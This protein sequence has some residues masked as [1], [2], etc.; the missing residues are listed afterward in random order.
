MPKP[1]IVLPYD[2]DVEQ[3]PPSNSSNVVKNNVNMAQST[4]S[5]YH[6]YLSR[7]TRLL[8]IALRLA[9][10]NIIDE[11]LN[12]RQ[13]DGSYNGNS[14]IFK[15]LY[16]TQRKCHNIPGNDELISLLKEAKI[17]RELI[18]NES[19]LQKMSK[20][21]NLEHHTPPLVRYSNE[22]LD[23]RQEIDKQIKSFFNNYIQSK[24][25]SSVSTPRAPP[26]SPDGDTPVQD[27]PLP[28]TPPQNLKRKSTFD[29]PPSK[30]RWE[31]PFSESDDSD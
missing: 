6:D 5:N 1:M 10:I 7:I 27:I 18:V 11:D 4:K 21:M 28:L 14:N 26:P 17:P 23:R 22:E 12:V 8:K 13:S 19:I 29:I 20:N 25:T 24:P 16:S 30:R 9:K 2:K 15:L 3:T 31:I